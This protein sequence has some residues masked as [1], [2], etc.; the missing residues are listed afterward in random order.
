[1]SE[2]NSLADEEIVDGQEDDEEMDLD[3]EPELNLK[4]SEDEVEDDDGDD[5]DIDD[6]LLNS[7]TSV[8][9]TPESPV[10][11][12]VIDSDVESDMNETSLVIDTDDDDDNYD[13]DDIINSD[14]SEEETVTEEEFKCQLC[15]SQFMTEKSLKIHRSQ[16]AKLQKTRE[17]KFK[18]SQTAGPPAAAVPVPVSENNSSNTA[19]SSTSSSAVATSSTTGGEIIPSHFLV[20][21]SPNRKKKKTQKCNVCG[22]LFSQKG[23]LTRHFETIHKNFQMKKCNLCGENFFK[24]VELKRHK[25][26]IHGIEYPSAVNTKVND[27]PNIKSVATSLDGN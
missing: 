26:Q 8:L 4:L 19:A 14:N 18:T 11:R 20:F 2:K 5:T 27:S 15:S 7:F 3:D 16:C 25:H 9:T 13:G 24:L 6:D 23:S 17:I 22:K 1:M 21:P 10:K 12:L